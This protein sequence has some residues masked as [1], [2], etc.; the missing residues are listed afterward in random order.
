M[1]GASNEGRQKSGAPEMRG[2]KI[3]AR[4][5]HRV[6]PSLF[7]PFI[8]GAVASWRRCFLAPVIPSAVHSAS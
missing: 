8:P 2:V 6:Q 5:Q 4:E 3:E 7:T 1:K